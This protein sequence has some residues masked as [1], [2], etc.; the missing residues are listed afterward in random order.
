MLTAQE[1][2]KFVE[3]RKKEDEANE[4]QNYSLQSM[5]NKIED[6]SKTGWNR[7]DFFYREDRLISYFNNIEELKKLGYEIEYEKVTL[8]DKLF[9]KY[10]FFTVKW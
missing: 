3:T 4:K 2:N 1:A 9:S 7:I 8:F 5:L 6:Y 10:R